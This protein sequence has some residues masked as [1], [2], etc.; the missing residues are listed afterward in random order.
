MFVVEE[1]LDSRAYDTAN[2][3]E[4][5]KAEEALTYIDLTTMDLNIPSPNSDRPLIILNNGPD[6]NPRAIRDGR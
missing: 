4:E 1:G 6:V 5:W 3:W 2:G